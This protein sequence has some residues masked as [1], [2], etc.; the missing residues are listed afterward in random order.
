ML[1]VVTSAEFSMSDDRSEPMPAERSATE[2][3]RDH[4]PTTL[5]SA[6]AATPAVPASIA[7]S[8]RRMSEHMP[9]G[10]AARH[11][12]LYRSTTVNVTVFATAVVT[13]FAVTSAVR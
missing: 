7:Q 10:H 13:A 8:Q 4:A 11:G 9:G 5:M 6:A 1:S 3:V 2:A 12:A